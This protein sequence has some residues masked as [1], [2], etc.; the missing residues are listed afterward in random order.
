MQQRLQTNH[1]SQTR[2]FFSAEPARVHIVQHS[3]VSRLLRMRLCAPVTQTLHA[4]S[5]MTP[6]EHVVNA[7]FASVVKEQLNARVG[8]QQRCASL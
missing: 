3:F 5:C 8:K 1:A 7:C 4:P 2:I 6:R